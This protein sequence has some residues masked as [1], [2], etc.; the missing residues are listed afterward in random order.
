M[1]VLHILS[2][3]L[4]DL[5]ILDD[6][7]RD[8][9]M[10]DEAPPAAKFVRCSRNHAEKLVAA[11]LKRNGWNCYVASVHIQG[12]PS[13]IWKHPDVRYDTDLGLWEACVT[14]R[15]WL[16]KGERL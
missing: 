11:I 10:D 12:A 9:L 13:H 7:L 2:A 8:L 5:A 15:N 6:Y 14:T 16:R 3:H 1:K 4:T